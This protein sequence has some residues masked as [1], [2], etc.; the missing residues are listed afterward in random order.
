MNIHTPSLKLWWVMAAAVLRVLVLSPCYHESLAVPTVMSFRNLKPRYSFL[1]VCLSQDNYIMVFWNEIPCSLLH[2]YQ[3][4]QRSCYIHLTERQQVPVKV[5]TCLPHW[6]WSRPRSQ[7]VIMIRTAV[8]T[9]ILTN[10]IKSTWCLYRTCYCSNICVY[11]I[12]L[13]LQ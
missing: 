13:V 9:S 1:Y 5:G 12:S 4:F 3:H 6:M 2:G 10:R 7:S 11:V 8:T